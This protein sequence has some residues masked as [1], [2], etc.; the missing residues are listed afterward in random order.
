MSV[1]KKIIISS[2]FF[3]MALT[4]NAQFIFRPYARETPQRIRLHQH[5]MANRE[6]FAQKLMEKIDWK[7]EIPESIN[8]ISVERSHFSFRD[9]FRDISELLS[10]HKG[11][12]RTSGSGYEYYVLKFSSTKNGEVN[13]GQ[14]DIRIR[15]GIMSDAINRRMEVSNCQSEN[16]DLSDQTFAIRF[17]EIDTY[18]IHPEYKD[19]RSYRILEN[20]S[21]EWGLPADINNDSRQENTPPSRNAEIQGT[22]RGSEA[23]SR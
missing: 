11:V 10:D 12:T 14:C 23:Q 16:L 9:F 21:V 3:F 20:H 15:F 4:L 18:Y 22:S 17:H 5:H 2:Y 1:N 7:N 8:V 19:R 13:E 6:V